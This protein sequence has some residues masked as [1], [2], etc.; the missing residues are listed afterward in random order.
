MVL[1]LGGLGTPARAATYVDDPLTSG[2]HPGRGARGGT[3]SGSGWTTT[4]EPDAVWY[5]ISDALPS[6]RI[7]YTVTGLSLATSLLGYDHD[8]LTV[9]QAPDGMAEPIAYMPGFR[10]NDFKAFTRIFGALETGRPGA[11]KLELANCVQGS[12]WYHDTCPQG[13]GFDEIAYATGGQSPGW[14]AA[15][16]YRMVLEW[17][18]GT[19]TFSRDGV[20]L[21]SATY[22]GTYAPKPMRVR[23][24]SPRHDNAY[25]GEAFMPIGI[26]IKDVLITG[27]PGVMT[28]A[29]GAPPPT[30]DAGMGPDARRGGEPAERPPIGDAP[31]APVLEAVLE[32]TAEPVR[33]RLRHLR[34][35]EAPR[36]ELEAHAL[37]GP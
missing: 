25:P 14:D 17:G 20:V 12:P 28:L 15:T 16:S 21:G 8:I 31:F 7:E 11:M 6:A 23:L 37:E 22:P 13:C 10:N 4:A 29:C 30:V 36:R 26:T 34:A 24:G 19:M 27:T 2:S 9:Y 32:V 33:Q 35:I 3:F 1:A 18:N 5:E